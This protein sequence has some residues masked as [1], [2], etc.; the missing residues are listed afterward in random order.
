MAPL[1]TS[2]GGMKGVSIAMSRLE[3][4]DS[5]GGDIA[6]PLH[7]LHLNSVYMGCEPRSH[8]P[9]RPARNHR[10]VRILEH[11]GG[12]HNQPVRRISNLVAHNLS[13]AEIGKGRFR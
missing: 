10:L 9:R 8:H 1:T 5:V 2:N 7:G 12:G 3:M 4:G 11:R 6:V 13:V